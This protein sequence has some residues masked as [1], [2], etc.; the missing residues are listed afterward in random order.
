[1]GLSSCGILILELASE[2]CR[3]R[4]IGTENKISKNRREKTVSSIF[5]NNNILLHLFIV[6]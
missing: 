2:Q 6:L 4:K 3:S 1:M 5:F